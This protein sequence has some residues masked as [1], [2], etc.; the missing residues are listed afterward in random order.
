VTPNDLITLAL[1]T[2]GVLGIGQTPDP[3]DTSDAFTLLNM[4]MGQWSKKRWLIYHL[5]DLPLISTG[6]YSYTIGPYCDF[7][8]P[9]PDRIEAAFVRQPASA[10]APNGLLTDTIGQATPFNILLDGFSGIAPVTVGSIMV[11]EAGNVMVSESGQVMASEGQ[12]QVIDPNAVVLLQETGYPIMLR[13]RT[14]L[15]TGATA[16]PLM[17]E[18]GVRLILS[19]ASVYVPPATTQVDFPV[20]ILESREDYNKIAIKAL[21]TLPSFVFYDSGWPT[22]TLYFWPVAPTSM[23]ELHVTVK[24]Q[25]QAFPNMTDDINLPPEYAE[26]LM[27]NLAARMRP[28]YGMLPDPTISALAVASLNTVRGANTQIPRLRMPTGIARRGFYNAQA[29][30]YT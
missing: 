6:A 13:E 7:N 10:L 24:D 4:M 1:K 14:I 25:L 27:F 22:G 30:W 28:L 29:N 8:T 17:T 15:P 23:Y 19:D 26:A 11:D 20:M 2:A 16:V 18:A 12:G 21:G 3:S 5:L 9:R